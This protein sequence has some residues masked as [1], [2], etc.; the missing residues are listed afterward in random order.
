M[1]TKGYSF[2]KNKEYR[3]KMRQSL[4][5][6]WKEKRGIKQH[7]KRNDKGYILIYQPSHPFCNYQG[8]VYEHR[9]V[10]E[11]KLGRYLKPKERIHHINGIRGDN[12]QEN[13]Q[14][15]ANDNE[16][17]KLHFPEGSRFGKNSELVLA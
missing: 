17:A 10:M 12:H 9:L 5:N 13:L 1:S 7:G 3:A 2:Y 14:L 6:Y 15:F 16:H 4:F 11:K 8:Y